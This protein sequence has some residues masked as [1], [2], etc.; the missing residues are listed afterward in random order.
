MQKLTRG[1][2]EWLGFSSLSR[3]CH[4]ASGHFSSFASIRIF[5][6]SFITDLFSK[7]AMAMAM[8]MPTWSK[9]WISNIS[10]RWK[11]IH[12]FIWDSMLGRMSDRYQHK[13]DKNSW[14]EKRKKAQ[15]SENRKNWKSN[16]CFYDWKFSVWLRLFSSS[17]PFGFAKGITNIQ[18]W[19]LL[20]LYLEQ[21]TQ[22]FYA[23]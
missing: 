5:N 17:M 18:S 14:K 8:T 11:K 13:N 21:N 19:C 9:T 23:I 20:I 15:K 6:S 2:F 12:P 22:T 10:I 1:P 3:G 7:M 4:S 16:K